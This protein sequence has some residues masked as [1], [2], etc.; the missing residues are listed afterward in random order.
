MPGHRKRRQF[1]QTDAFTRGMV[2]GLKRAGWSKRQIAADTHFGASTMHRLWRRWLEQGNV[3]IY[4]NAGATRVTSARVDRRILR[5]AVTAPQATCTAI[6]Q[7]VQDTLDHSISTRTISR[8]LIANGLHSCRPL[9]RLPLTP[10][11]RRQRLEW[12]RARSTWM[13]EWHRVVF[14]DESRFCLSSDS[15]RVRVWRRR[16]E[17]SNPVAIVERPTV[18]QRGIMVWGAIAYDSRSHL[19]C[20]Q[21]T[22]TAQ[23]YIDDVLRRVTLPYLHGLPN[24]LYQQDNARQHTARI[25]QQALQDVQML[26][27][28]P[29][30]PDLSPIEHVWD[31]IGRRLHALPQPRSE[32]ELWQMVEREWRAIPQDA[33]RTLIDSLPRRAAACI[34]V[35]DNSCLETLGSLRLPRQT[36]KKRDSPARVP[37]QGYGGAVSVLMLESAAKASASMLGTASNYRQSQTFTKVCLDH[38]AMIN[39]SCTPIPHSMRS[40]VDLHAASPVAQNK[41]GRV[42]DLGRG[43]CPISIIQSPQTSN[44]AASKQLSILQC[45]INGLCS[46]ATKIKLEE[47]ME[48]AEKQKIQIIALQETKLNEKYNLK[49]KNYNILRKDRNKEGGGLAF[50]IKNLYYEDIAINIP[51]TSDLEAQ[52]IKVYLNQNKTINIFN[53]YH[54]PNNKLIDDGTM[55]QFLT[56]N[57][58]IVGDLNAKHQL[59]GCSTPNPRG[60]ILSNLFDDNAFMCLNDG[61]PTHH[62]YSY[63]TAQALD[64]SFSSPDIFHKCK[65][66]ILKSIGSDHLPI[67]IEISTKTKT[68]SIKEK[69]WNFKKANWNLY[70]QNTNEDF[71]KAPT[72]IKDLEQNWICFKNTIIKAAKVSIPRGNIKK[73]IPNYTHQAKDIQ[74]LI[75]KRNELQKKC[76]QNQTNCRT[77]L[78]IVNAKIKRLYVNM[79]REKW[80]QTC[81]NLNPRNPNTKLWHLAKQIDRA[82]PQTENTNMIKNT[83]GTPA[84]ND[85]NAANLLGNSYQISSKIKFEIKDKKVEKKARKIIHDCKNVTSTHNIFHEKIN[86]KELDYALENTDLNKTPGPDGIHGQMISNLGKNGKEKLLDIFNNSWKTGKLPQDW[87]TATI[88]PIKKLDKSADDPKNYRPI[89]LTSICCKLMEKIILRRLTYHLDTRNLLPKEQYGFRKGHGTIDQLLFFTQKVKDAQNRKPTN[90]TI[91]AFLDLTQAFDKVWKNKLI[92]KLY[93]HFKIDG[94][95]ITW[96]ND[97]LKNRYIRVKYNGTLSK[98]FKLY[99]GL[100]QGS[101]LSPT[102]FTLFIAGIEEKISHKTNIGLFADDI[103]LWSSNTNWKKA[104]RDLNK[105]LF[106]L[107]KFANKHKLE[108]N[109]QKSETCLFTTDKKLYKIRPKIIL[110]EQQLQYNKHPKYL[111]Y[112]L[113]PEINSSKHIEEVI[114]KGRDRLKILKYISG[115]EWGADAT[116]LKLTYTSLIRPILEYGYQI[117]GT[118]SETNLKSLERIQLSAARIITGLRNTCPNDIVLYEADIMPLKDRRS[119]NLPKYINKIKSYG[120]KH[121]TSK[122]ILNWE[123]NLRLKKEGPLH[124]AKRNEFLKYKVEKNYLA[125]KMSPCKPLQ[126]VIF[127]ATLNEPTNKQYQ[128]PE[129]LKQLSLEIINNIPKNAITIYTD[130][131][132]DELGHTG[133]GCLIK[134]TNGIE[135]MN[136]RNPDFC[137][138]F[139]SELIA[140]YEALKSIRNTNYQDI[141]ILTDSRSAIQHLSHTGELRDKVSRNIIG[142]LQKLSKTSKIHLQWI[143]SHVGIEGNEAADVLAKKGTK[144]PLPQ[145]NKLTFKEI[146]TIAKTKINKNWRIPPKHSW[147][148]GVNPGGALKIRNRQHQTTLTRFRTGHL[149]PLKIENNNKI[150]PTCPKCSLAP[151]APEHILACIRCTKQD[152]WERPLLIIKQLEEH[153]LMEFLRKRLRDELG[154]TPQCKRLRHEFGSTPQCKRL[155]HEL[156]STPQC[157]RLRHVLGSTPQCKRLRHDLGSTPQ[158]KRLRHELGSTPQCKRLRYEL[159]STP[160]C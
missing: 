83:D 68:S 118:A 75:T 28:P 44:F 102:L 10:P 21:G 86:M 92:T 134:T 39:E 135:K 147:Y 80:K 124:L 139:R 153:E 151:A 13:T 20:I 35:R 58:I 76:T 131:S 90:H 45:N 19:L 4:R 66:Q 43:F 23:R 96:I 11:N 3:A 109:P 74:T 79:K 100:P 12:C 8:R 87:K 65:W 107:E 136:R 103:I 133:S 149:K 155:R 56:D 33:I 77:E 47:I 37:L 89:S 81:E 157:K 108:F 94:K 123:S 159:G 126:N 138:V 24:A 52:G 125:E 121:R 154:S 73:W 30:S 59:W 106:H 38:G 26:S 113:D 1:K 40:D 150:Y 99:Q 71:R 22:M 158:C 18:R 51:N 85:K 63:N 84:T 46:T 112:T 117:Y 7:H 93:K 32:D 120:N 95:A 111:G 144:E 2:I 128:N 104:E 27:W 122:Y 78:N 116:T 130:G 140:I 98:T 57:T 6:L 54:P 60:K 15:R 34:A 88:I 31:I 142:Y 110:K 115:R 143:P 119:Y 29:Y 25:S 5:Q 62:S 97:F 152:L 160:Q 70:Q 69:F 9:R 141:W 55:A 132:R 114:R 82:Q 50:L 127:N 148:S 61:N 42:Q 53:M 137:S 48:I 17:R 145:K 91:A 101:V 129:Y 36:P 67:L 41:Q 72:R 16:G 14:S 146:E 156:G 64:I 49:Y 105:T